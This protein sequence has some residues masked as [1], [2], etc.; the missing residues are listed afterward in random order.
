MF[1]RELTEPTSTQK[2][3]GR[4]SSETLKKAG[5]TTV[6]DLLLHIPRNYE[7]RQ[8]VVPI[9]QAVAAGIAANTVVTVIT[10]DYIGRGKNATLKIFIEDE[11]ARA[12]LLCFGRN[13]LR[14]ALVP[15]KRY[16]LYGQFS[17]K[18]NELQTSAFETEPYTQNPAIFGNILP[19]YPLYGSLTQ[20]FFRNVIQAALRN[21]APDIENELPERIVEKYG[22][23]QKSRAIRLV[24]FPGSLEQA[25]QA[26]KSLGYEEFFYLQLVIKRRAK[27][28]KA[29]PR[30]SGKI[31]AGLAAKLEARLP[32]GLTTDQR[33]VL[34]EIRDDLESGTPMMRLL[35]G[36][37]GCGKTLVAFIAALFAVEAGEQAAMMAPTELLAR[38]HAETA[39][40][41]L[42]PLGVRVALLSGTVAPRMRARLLEALACGDIDI[43]LGTHAL[44]SQ[45]VK[46]KRLRLVIIDEQHRFGVLQR[47]ALVEKGELG[48]SPPDMLLMTATP[49]PRSL[50]LTVFGDLD[51]STI[52][53]M[54]PGR[55]PVETHLARIGNEEKVYS[56]VSREVKNGRQAY[57]VYPLIEQSENL[58]LKDAQSMFHNLKSRVF[59]DLR[60]ALLHSRLPE[61]EKKETMDLFVG[62]KID[63][64]V[65]T[66]VI[67]V[68]V[69]VPNATCMVVEH[70]E[71]FGLSALHQLRGR[72][73][74]AEHQSYAF[75][76]YDKELTE[77]G[78]SRLKAIKETTDGFVIAE[79]D[80][81]IR[82]PGELTGVRQ[83]GRF[84]LVFVD[85]LRDLEL[86][87]TARAD[88][89]Q[90]LEDDPGLIDPQNRVV[91]T[92]LDR[93]PPFSEETA[94]G[95]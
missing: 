76:I 64:L 62:G 83:A 69:N 60:L 81:S 27:K 6:A 80:L 49:I 66:S 16:F 11:S 42:E 31:G 4:V 15:G 51:V 71:R 29:S 24:H 73:G 92:V 65:A 52:R 67:E 53:T 74:R 20:R 75:F 25:E 48:K 22:L 63:I 17:Y 37:V 72:V 21:Y 57:F 8:T 1:L 2:G 12:A 44:F 79:K 56:W 5:I 40:S 85:I 7:D 58:E 70:A 68:G 91:R 78:R 90:L 43:L 59:P 28:L 30:H 61:E 3:I 50:A 86:L 13:F 33:K 55:K 82:G 41:M 19:V 36:D 84:K 39:A 95:G 9:A 10:H 32:F 35:Q 54:P 38:Q 23:E 93:V 89:E 26:K 14:S 46:F 18:Y 47:L 94:A 88:V 77:E 87:K 45:D 34:A